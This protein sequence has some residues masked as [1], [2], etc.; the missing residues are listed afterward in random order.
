MALN[1]CELYR[2]HACISFQQSFVVKLLQHRFTKGIPIILRTKI[3]PFPHIIRQ[4]YTDEFLSGC[5]P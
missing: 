3:N 2:V 1:L 5:Y 4:L